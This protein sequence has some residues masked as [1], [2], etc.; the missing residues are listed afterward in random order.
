MASRTG[1]GDLY[2]RLAVLCTGGAVLLTDAEAHSMRRSHSVAMPA[3]KAPNT[4]TLGDASVGMGAA[5]GEDI[6]PGVM[7]EPKTLASAG[8]FDSG[9]SAGCNGAASAVGACS[10]AAVPRS[11]G[12]LCAASRTRR[13][14][15]TAELC[16]ART[17]SRNVTSSDFG[18]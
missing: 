9:C 2:D 7:G 14:S 1:P 18:R 10:L 16:L 15:R 8:V 4:A 12:V 5:I 6:G 11:S 17:S 3:S 13:L